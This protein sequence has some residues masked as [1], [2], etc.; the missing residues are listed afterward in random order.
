[1]FANADGQPWCRTYIRRVMLRACARAGVAP[2]SVHALRRTFLTRLA[3]SGANPFAIRD[4]ARHRSI[5]TT[6]S[7]LRLNLRYRSIVDA[8][9]RG[10]STTAPAMVEDGV[11]RP[12]GS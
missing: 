8:A 6:E 11:A 7:Y 12:H 3:E 10:S 1:M 4:L 5:A 2:R 9:E